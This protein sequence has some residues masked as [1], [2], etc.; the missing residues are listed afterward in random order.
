MMSK[1]ITRAQLLMM[2]ADLVSHHVLYMYAA[3]IRAQPMTT[4]YQ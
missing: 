4:L 3:I 2:K 1:H